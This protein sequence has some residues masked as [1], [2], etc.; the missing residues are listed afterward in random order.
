MGKIGR[1]ID[2][3]VTNDPDLMRR[4]HDRP[5][6]TLGDFLSTDDDGNLC[7]CM[8]GTMLLESGR[9]SFWTEGKAMAGMADRR[10]YQIGLDVIHILAER[11]ARG[12]SFPWTEH[13]LELIRMLKG[14]IARAL[15]GVES[16][17]GAEDETPC[18]ISI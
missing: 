4:V 12:K 3:A 15:R 1:F 5:W 11:Q 13:E 16:S 2:E 17:P 14:R 18:A 7:G 9:R 10:V 6:G 8:A